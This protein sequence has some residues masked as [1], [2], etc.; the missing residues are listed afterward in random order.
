MEPRTDR[1]R[2]S[3]AKSQATENLRDVPMAELMAKLNSSRDGLSQHKA[4]KRLAHYGPNEIKEE[5]ANSHLRF[6]SYF[7]G[8]IPWMIEVAVIQSGVVGH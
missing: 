3:N 6:L 8:P 2:G 7:W 4:R 1:S 5:K